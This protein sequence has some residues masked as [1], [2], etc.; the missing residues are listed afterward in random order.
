MISSKHFK[1][2]EFA[3][4]C[5]CGF[6]TIDTEL[7]DI[8]N[9]LRAHFDRPIVISSGCRCETHNEK[10]GGA[11]NSQHLYGRA[12]DLRV[13][14]VKVEDVFR[15]LDDTYPYRLGLKKYST[16]VHVDTRTTEDGA[17]W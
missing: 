12:V 11:S 14:G 9:D 6:D 16:W 2:S 13:H 8:L 7:L 10:E 15:Y 5:G 4:K 1:R 3:C 17:R